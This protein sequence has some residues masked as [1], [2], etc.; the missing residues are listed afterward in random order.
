MVTHPEALAELVVTRKSLD[1]R[2]LTL[3][4][5]QTVEVDG[6]VKQLRELGFREVD[7]VYEPGQFA[8]RGS[9]LDVFS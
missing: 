3:E 6:V 2:T 4:Q 1:A 8:L 9:I 7:Y 5:N